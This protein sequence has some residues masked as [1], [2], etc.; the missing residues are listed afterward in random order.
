MAQQKTANTLAFDVGPYGSGHIIHM[1][2]D[3]YPE[4]GENGRL[5]LANVPLMVDCLDQLT[6]NEIR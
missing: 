5:L 4:A 1:V 3:I 6:K 2:D